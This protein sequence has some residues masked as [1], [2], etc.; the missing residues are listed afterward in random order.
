[1]TS[2]LNLRIDADALSNTLKFVYDADEVMYIT[3]SFFSLS[4]NSTL[5]R[6]KVSFRGFASKPCG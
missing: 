4:P 6:S 3:Q 1:M 5:G 2:G